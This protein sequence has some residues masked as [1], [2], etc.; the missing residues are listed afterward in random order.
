MEPT[1]YYLQPSALIASVA[2][3]SGPIQLKSAAE[4][5]APSS[6]R[7]VVLDDSALQV[8]SSK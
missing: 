3:H 1:T 7:C 6:H 5:N 4:R 2:G 8:V